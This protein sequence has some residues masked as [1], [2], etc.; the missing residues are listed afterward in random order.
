MKGWKIWRPEKRIS[1][2]SMMLMDDH[3]C[4]LQPIPRS[5]TSSTL[6]ACPQ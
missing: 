6:I 2:S 4:P 5:I 1:I 3:P